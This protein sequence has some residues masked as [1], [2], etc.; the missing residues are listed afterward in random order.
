MRTVILILLFACEAT[1]V[2]ID[3]NL[4]NTTNDTNSQDSDSPDTG[5]GPGTDPIDTALDTDTNDTSPDTD[6]DTNIGDTGETQ[7]TSDTGIVDTDG[8]G[9]SDDDEILYGTDPNNPDSDG[10]GVTDGDEVHV[11]FTEPTNPDTDS[12]GLSDGD[13]IF[14]HS[15]DPLNPDT[16]GDGLTDTAEIFEHGTSPVNSDTDD[17]GADDGYEVFDETDPTDPSDDDPHT[18]EGLWGG[19]F[20]VDT[21]SF[22]SPINNGS[23]DSHKHEYDD[24]FNVTGVDFFDTLGTNLHTIE[25]DVGDPD[26]PFRLIVINSDLSI[27]GRLVV[28][29]T[30]DPLNGSTWTPTTIYDNTVDTSLPV[31][32]F[33]GANGTTA[34]TQAG[35][36]FHPLAILHGGLHPTN[37]GCVKDNELGPNNEW[38]NGA[39]TIQAIAMNTDGSE[40]YTTDYSMSNGGQQGVATSGLLWEMTLFWHWGGPCYHDNG[41]STY[42]P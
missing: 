31:Y 35:I 15:T 29:Q 37:T 2:K 22:I 5:D 41:W 3:G 4:L 36:Y 40:A 19:H 10:D 30:Y 16:D 13:E 17:G 11:Y 7:D 32:S 24:D 1:S 21:S 18:E 38:R 25:T 14:T 20:D 8:D 39:V 28:N 23:T 34:L 33:S 9:L 6:T 42:T 27:G 12:D 26:Q